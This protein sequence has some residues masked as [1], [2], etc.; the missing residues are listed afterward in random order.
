M[1][2]V[3]SFFQT[4]AYKE[5]QRFKMKVGVFLFLIKD[6]KILLLRRA[7]TGIDDG[8]YVVPMGGVDGNESLT[9]ACIREAYE[10]ANIRI[11]TKDIQVRHVMH[12]FHPMPE[13][14]SFEQMDV[15]FYATTFEGEIY[16]NEPHK[17]DELAFYSLDTLPETMVPFIRSALH[18]VQSNVF[19]SEF[20]WDSAQI[21]TPFE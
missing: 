11:Q 10:E 20:G 21:S 15:F 14:F 9:T 17:C 12:R 4:F 5:A 13:G 16:N 8:C 3:D 7:Q 19:F 6:E 2:G 18:S 1:Q